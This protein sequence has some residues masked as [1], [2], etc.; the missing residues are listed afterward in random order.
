MKNGT[1]IKYLVQSGGIGLAAL[2]AYLMFNFL[3]ESQAQTNGVIKDVSSAIQ[4]NTQA[5]QALDQ[6]IR[7][8][9]SLNQPKINAR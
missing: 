5:I 6:Y 2:F 8:S 3:A 4:A 7:D 1:L 9:R